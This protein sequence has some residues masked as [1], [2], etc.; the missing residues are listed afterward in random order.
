MSDNGV[1]A[2]A[3]FRYLLTLGLP[4]PEPRIAALGGRSRTARARC[5]APPTGRVGDSLRIPCLPGRTAGRGRHDT[6]NV[7]AQ[8]LR[9]DDDARLS[10]NNGSLCRNDDDSLQNNS[11]N[12]LQSADNGAQ[13]LSRVTTTLG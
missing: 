4:D 5:C 6:D 8:L 2:L 9:N 1:Q 11:D 13:M 12:P 10:V 7:D 3:K